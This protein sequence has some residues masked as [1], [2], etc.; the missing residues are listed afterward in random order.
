MNSRISM[1][2]VVAIGLACSST[3]ARQTFSNGQYVVLADA[4]R[5]QG[6][7]LF[8]VSP[9]GAVNPTPIA[10]GQ[11]SGVISLAPVV[12][13]A[14]YADRFRV[15]AAGSGGAMSVDVF[16][17]LSIESGSVWGVPGRLGSALATFEDPLIAFE[18]PLIASGPRLWPRDLVGRARDAELG[19]VPGSGGTMRL[20]VWDAQDPM[21]APAF[22][23]APTGAMRIAVVARSPG[24][25]SSRA[26]WSCLE[27]SRWCRPAH[28]WPRGCTPWDRW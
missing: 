7:A 5:G 12:N 1:W 19:L 17:S 26:P 22:F 10:V 11:L 13:R 3:A 4:P 20:A 6:R 21:A 18:D 15:F 16:Q 24:R 9:G 14:T 28:P 23:A 27:R 25:V 8:L 2:A